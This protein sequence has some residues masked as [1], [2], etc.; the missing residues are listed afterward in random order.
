MRKIAF[1]MVGMALISGPFVGQAMAKPSNAA[2]VAA[3]QKIFGL[4]N[5]DPSTG[6]VRDDKVVFSWLTNATFGASMKGHVVLLDSFVTRLEVVPGRTPLV[7]QD[8]VDLKPEAIFLG[9]GHFD[10]ADNAAYIAQQTGAVIYASPETC[11]NMAIDAARNFAS[12]YTPVATVVCK[13]LTTR[14]ST[15]GSQIVA[16]NDFEP[17]IKISVFKHLHST[18]TG[19]NDPDAVPIAATVGGACVPTLTKGN[20]FPCNLQDPRD[21]MLFP[22]GTSLSTVMNIA[23][24]RTGAGGP[25]SLFYVFTVNGD[26]KFRFVWHNTTG[27]IVD[28]CAL[29]N[30]N[31][32]GVPNEPG[33]SVTGCFPGV[34]VNGK[35]VGAN[36]ASIMD[37]LGPVDVELGSVVSLGYSQNG[38][39]DI[40]TYIEHVR[41]RFFIPNH[42]TAVAVEGSS[43]E[44]KVGFYDALRAA[45]VP[46]NTWPDTLWLVDPNDYLRPIVFQP[47]DSER[48]RSG[49]D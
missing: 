17:A 23:T 29:P 4:E 19:V 43:L 13:P 39:R 47:G 45:N 15:P 18:N 7:I 12:G 14:G 34:T 27:D 35:T 37:G 22:A 16:I 49:D 26:D 24:A 10:H 28:S 46:Q 36:L 21:P 42:V 25:I 31:S 2:L 5:V 48:N 38:E 40:V 32:A 11:D 20:T 33:Q 44:W 30:N 41:P 6:R 8:L 3:R 1:T 9:H